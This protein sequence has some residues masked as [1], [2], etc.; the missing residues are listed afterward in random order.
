MSGGEATQ[1]QWWFSFGFLCYSGL[2]LLRHFFA[3]LGKLR[4]E[5]KKGRFFTVIIVSDDWED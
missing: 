5:E 4:A 3:H 1:K 2:H